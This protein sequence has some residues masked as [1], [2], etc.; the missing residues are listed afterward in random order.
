MLRNVERFIDHYMKGHKPATIRSV[1][2]TL[3]CFTRFLYERGKIKK[4]IHTRIRNVKDEPF[5]PVLISPDQERQII[6][7]PRIWSKYHSY[8][9]RRRYDLF[10]ELLA[11]CGLRC[12]E[13]LN[14]KVN[15]FNFTNGEF[16]LIGKGSEV[17]TIPIPKVILS[18]LV[19]WIKG[20]EL[21]P[22][23]YVF[24]KERGGR[25]PSRET[26]SGEL[27]KRL[28]ILGL[29]KSIHQHTFRHVFITEAYRA[30]MNPIK[31][32]RLVG[33][34]SLK[35]HLR[36]M[37]LIGRDLHDIVDEH[38][39]NKPP[40]AKDLPAKPVVPQFLVRDDFRIN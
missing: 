20:K 10:F 11:G 4:E 40:T 27:K 33:H 17:R 37:H 13:T 22:N 16:T 19:G 25:K 18:N 1:V 14:L 39:V 26:F 29:D 32:M 28:E 23:D 12:S 5:K 6:D 21:R 34:T 24:A 35:T 30:D 36:Y 31:V 15:D 2:N 7:C 8:I 9:D 38:P 3:K